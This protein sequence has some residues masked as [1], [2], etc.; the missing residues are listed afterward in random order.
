MLCSGPERDHGGARHGIRSDPIDLEQ[1]VLSI[2]QDLGKDVG[3]EAGRI[4][5]CDGPWN[6]SRRIDPL[7]TLK[8]ARHEDDRSILSPARG[9]VAASTG[10]LDPAECDRRSPFQTHLLQFSVREE[11][12]PASIR[13]K[14]RADGSVGAGDRLGRLSLEGTDEETTTGI[15]ERLSVRGQRQRI[16]ISAVLWLRVERERE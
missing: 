13:R 2:R 5:S 1:N 15:D 10:L 12:Q 3:F 8:V 11:S 16:E 7:K 14:E 6:A 9:A 4:D